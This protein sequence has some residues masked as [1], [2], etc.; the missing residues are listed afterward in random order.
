MGGFLQENKND[1]MNFAIQIQKSVYKSQNENDTVPFAFKFELLKKKKK[2][3]HFL[4]L[5]LIS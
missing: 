1:K 3:I 2:N 4:I 5:L